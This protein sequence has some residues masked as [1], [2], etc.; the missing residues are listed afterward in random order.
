ML[1][2]R[3]TRCSYCNAMLV[4]GP[5]GWVPAPA[6]HAPEPMRHTTARRLWLG[7][8]RY[9]LLGRL[10]RG[11][12]SDVFLA[13]RDGR[14]TERVVLKILRHDADRKL[15]EHEHDVLG[16]IESSPAQ[17]APHFSRLLPQRVAIG[18]ARLGERGEAGERF[19]SAFRWRSGF[20]HTADDVM[21]SHPNGVPPEHVVW[22]WK[23]VLELLGWLHAT[24]HVHGAVIPAHWL[25]HARDHGVVLCGWSCAWAAGAP[26][27]AKHAG[28]QAYYPP[29]VRVGH[30][31]QPSLDVEMSARVASRLLGGTADAPPEHVPEPIRR[32]VLGAMVR[33]SNDAWAVKDRI[34]VAANEV[35][36]PPRFVKFEMPGWA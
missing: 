15:V 10:A 8:H 17:G 4:A 1:A 30:V 6:E 9:A 19:V 25:V 26:L 2:T 36:G 34:Q 22:M 23:R 33:T 3:A 11:A 20:V 35:F 5:G 12:G 29:D 32:V 16:A 24:G 7:G 13:E 21:A 31:L 27:Y 18:T 28:A 14:L